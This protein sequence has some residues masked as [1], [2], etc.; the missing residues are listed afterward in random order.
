[1]NA[2]DPR[3]YAYRPDVA[4]ARLL[5]NVES[6][7]FAEGVRHQVNVP[8]LGVHQQPQSDAM[9]TS[10][11]LMGEIVLVFAEEDGWAFAQ[12]EGDG[13]VGYVLLH[14]LSRE[15][16]PPTH[17]VAVPATFMYPAPSM[18]SQPATA[19]TMNA[20]VTVSGEEGK[21]SRLANGRFV[22]TSH[23]KPFSEHE[24]DFVA[25]AECFRHA[26]YYWGGKSVYGVDCSGLVQVALEACGI[27]AP[28]DSDMQEKALG[29]QLMV[30]D[31]VGLRRGDLVFWN[32]HV[33]I[34]RDDRNLLHANGYHMMAVEEPLSAAVERIA[35]IY[36]QISSVRRL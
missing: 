27:A 6:A 26:P 11:A 16:A 36:G 5:G 28:R 31:L 20:R 35:K 13:Y 14:G 24:M 8:L 7:R 15:I 3:L 33:G 21:F 29:H 30:N 12:I 4:D 22:Y 23:L 32:G 2:P 10:Q 25:V 18:K 1:M 17:R 19:I 34:M 9:Q